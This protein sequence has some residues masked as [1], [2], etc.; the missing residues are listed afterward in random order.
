LIE[1]ATPVPL[2]LNR[3]GKKNILKYKAKQLCYVLLE[4][5]PLQAPGLG[6]VCLVMGGLLN[7]YVTPW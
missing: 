4:K 1:K 7:Q 2:F 5:C 3:R 6:V